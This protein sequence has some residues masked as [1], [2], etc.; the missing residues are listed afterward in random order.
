MPNDA[1]TIHRPAVWFP[2]ETTEERPSRIG[3]ILIW[4]GIAMA[5]PTSPRGWQWNPATIAS[6]ITLA[7][8]IAGIIAAGAWFMGSMYE[9]QRQI[10]NRMDI[11]EKKADSADTKASYAAGIKDKSTGHVDDDKKEPE[12]QK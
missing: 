1:A 8:V 6:V 12:K 7:L 2:T 3:R 5:Q 11:I 10:L 4:T 9:Q